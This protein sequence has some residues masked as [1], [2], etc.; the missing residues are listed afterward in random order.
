MLRRLSALDWVRIGLFGA[1]IV[2]VLT[3]LLPEDTARES[4]GRIAPLLLNL[5]T[6]A[7]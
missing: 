7:C 3:G 6:T 2:F 5:D 1:G 4:L